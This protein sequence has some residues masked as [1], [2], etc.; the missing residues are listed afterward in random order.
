MT[1]DDSVVLQ[2]RDAAHR[3]FADLAERQ[4][5][6]QRA[7]VQAQRL[8]VPLWNDV[9]AAGFD[10]LLAGDMDGEGWPCAAEVLM[11]QGYHGVALPLAETL[12]ARGL[13]QQAGLSSEV[14]GPLSVVQVCA[15]GPEQRDV[16]AAGV[17]L[18][19][20]GLVMP[21]GMDARRLLVTW[22]SDDGRG[23]GVALFEPPTAADAWAVSRN[24]A[25]EPRATLL[26]MA[27]WSVCD[28]RLPMHADV[29]G[30]CALATSSLIVGAARRVLDLSI[31]YAN[32][33]VQFGRNIGKFQALQHALAELSCEIAAATMAVN[34]AAHGM[35]TR[36]AI[37]EVAVAKIRAGR[38]AGIAAAVGHQVHGA[39][40]FTDEHS[41]HHFTRRL[42][43]WRGEWGTER[44]WALQLGDRTIRSGG[45]QVWPHIV[46]MSR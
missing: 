46:E 4:K 31:A 7:D 30:L 41:L 36:I 33:R 44:E 43:S 26:R 42:W 28:G 5:K 40:G 35:E 37:D 14:P 29:H 32:D 23:N 9:E 19:A 20:T 12:V 27:G 39:I 18:N 17:R 11:A 24:T 45:A 22:A 2:V 1:Q 25:G 21:W 8:S 15:G 6:A 16:S 34:V 10:R 13:L 38:C 3:L